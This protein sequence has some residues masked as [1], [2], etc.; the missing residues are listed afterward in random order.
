[1][2]PGFICVAGVDPRTR[3]QIRPVIG[4]CF[5]RDFLR[6]N[7]GPFEI[8]AEVDLGATT[9]V[10]RAPAWEDYRIDPRNLRHFRRLGP[11]EFWSLLERTS[12]P[13]LTA[14]F[15]SALER[16]NCDRSCTTAEKHGS[17]SLG[18]LR[19][20][21]RAD[22]TTNFSGRARAT[23]YEAHFEF[24]I[25][26]TDF[27][28]CR[29]DHQTPRLKLIEDVRARLRSVPAILAVGLTRLYQKSTDEQARHWLQL[30]NI[31]LQ[32]DPL[33][34][35]LPPAPDDDE[36]WRSDSYPPLGP[37]PKAPS[38]SKSATASSRR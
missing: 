10:G 27:R 23:V 5:T 21:R 24:E 28:L 17:A 29:S 20:A 8:G 1:M 18:H 14:I 25:S 32:D 30:N 13:N 9:Y 15:G 11:T 6:H 7:G 22:I 37:D 19:P 38:L 16:R 26:V 4:T 2:K 12:Q 34:V 33:G 35:S 3:R 31:H 36:F